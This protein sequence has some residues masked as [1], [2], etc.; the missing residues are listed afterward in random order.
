M[1]PIVV[2]L[3]ARLIGV[4]AAPLVVTEVNGALGFGATGITTG[5]AAE[6]VMDSYGGVVTIGFACAIFQS[7]EAAGLGASGAALVVVVGGA[8]AGAAAVGVVGK[9]RGYT[10]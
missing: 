7:V 6:G 8:T 2:E 10:S 3:T 4:A 5:T 1:I 9:C